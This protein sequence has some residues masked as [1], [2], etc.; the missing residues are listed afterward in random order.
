[1]RR[2]AAAAVPIRLPCPSAGRELSRLADPP[3]RAQGPRGRLLYR[4]SRFVR[5]ARRPGGAHGGAGRGESA[6]PRHRPADARPRARAAGRAIIL[7]DTIST[8][9]TALAALELAKRAGAEIVGLA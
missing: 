9:A 1:F 4:Q 2:A 8:G 6:R 3:A 5:R 7:D